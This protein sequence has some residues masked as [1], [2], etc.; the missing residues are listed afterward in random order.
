MLTCAILVTSS[1]SKAY[2]TTWMV[3]ARKQFDAAGLQDMLTIG[4]DD[5]C[6]GQSDPFP[7]L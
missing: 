6:G 1:Q 5:C 4:T 2:N 3:E 7:V